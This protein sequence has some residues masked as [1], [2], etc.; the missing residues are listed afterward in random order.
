M[1]QRVKL[2]AA[3]YLCVLIAYL[4]LALFDEF[5]IAIVIFMLLVMAVSPFSE[6]ACKRHS[7]LP[8]LFSIVPYAYLIVLVM[9]LYLAKGLLFP[10]IRSLIFVHV[11]KILTPKE[12]NDHQIL[13]VVSAVIIAA[14]GIDVRT[15]AYAPLLISFFVASCFLLRFCHDSALQEEIPISVRS[16][17]KI[18][19]YPFLP[20]LLACFVFITGAIF[21]FTPR[22]SDPVF[23]VQ[24]EA[25]TALP[26]LVR[27]GDEGI[28]HTDNTVVLRVHLPDRDTPFST[29]PFWRAAT[30]E[31]FQGNE[32]RT[33]KR[34]VVAPDSIG[35]DSSVPDLP[36]LIRQEYEVV[37]E[38]SSV[39]LPAL[40]VAIDLEI[41]GPGAVVRSDPHDHSFRL[42]SAPLP[43]GLRYSV[44]SRPIQPDP[45]TLRRVS[46]PEFAV[47]DSPLTRYLDIC[48]LDGIDR[49]S[50][51]VTE[52]AVQLT[53]DEDVL[54]DK[55]TA[56]EEYLSWNYLYT[57]A[58]VPVSSRSPVEDFLFRSRRGHCEYFATTMTLL[59]RCVD[60]PARL[61]FGYR[62]GTWDP[63][64]R[65]Y[66]IR[67]SSSHAWVEVFFE[68]HGWIPFDPSASQ[69]ALA[70]E[71]SWL[72]KARLLIAR[73][74]PY[75]QNAFRRYV[76][77]FDAERQDFL[78]TVITDPLR[79]IASVAAG[80]T[81]GKVLSIGGTGQE[82]GIIMKLLGMS[83]QKLILSGAFVGILFSAILVIWIKGAK[84]A[85]NSG[86][87]EL[88]SSQ[89][90]A[91]RWA[92]KLRSTFRGMGYTVLPGITPDDL[93]KFIA[94]SNPT[95]SVM[96]SEAVAG[97]YAIRFGNADARREIVE[98]MNI[99]IALMTKKENLRSGADR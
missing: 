48:R 5:S 28:I 64:N 24:R 86:S 15:I 62:G 45:D 37:S 6:R 52:L 75:V 55:V 53:A 92:K 42:P 14:A 91:A 36:E 94:S 25:T 76:V 2:V 31:S 1:I 12:T 51:E 65:V 9:D 66:Q 78:G 97:Y 44:L 69:V 8:P 84:S 99:F 70:W 38:I 81:E 79:W 50:P 56:V 29:T 95:L 22:L 88:S 59:L 60:I 73:Y 58:P 47:E 80:K 68:G 7:W 72:S 89:Q 26:E 3:S 34:P 82:E 39:Y 43:P 20:A 96:G 87:R 74:Y 30:L 23:A 40:P 77:D 46:L 41:E 17:R 63:D 90:I 18:R 35:R 49:L 98:K 57:L 61:A 16:H 13:L 27:I 85:H 83:P 21:L 4:T 71:G 93:T 19:F 54:Y 33:A 32:W 10:L 67:S 11:Y